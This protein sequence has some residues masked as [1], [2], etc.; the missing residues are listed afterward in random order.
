M[1]VEIGREIL[2]IP[3]ADHIIIGDGR[4]YSFKEGARL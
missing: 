3:L 4:Y 1:D 2:G